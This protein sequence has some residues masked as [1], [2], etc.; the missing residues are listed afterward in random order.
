MQIITNHSQKELKHHGNYSFPFLV[1]HERLSRYESGSFLWH[2][3]PEVELTLIEQGEIIYHFSD[4]T[5]HAVAGDVLFGNS[6]ALHAG[7]MYRNHDC[8]YTPVTFDPRLIYGYDSSLI[9]QKYVEPI[10]QNTALTGLHLDRSA[11]W[12]EDA[13]RLIRESIAL[14][15]AQPPMYELDIIAGL[16]Q[17]WKLLFLNT[18]LP[19]SISA[20]D[21]RNSDRVRLILEYIEEHYA[22]PIRLEDIA[23]HIGLC[24]SECCR[25]FHRSMHMPLFEFLGE[26]RIEKSLH[27][28]AD[29][30]NSITVVAERA[31]FGDSNYYSK[32]FRKIKGCS[33]TK[34]RKQYLCTV[35]HEHSDTD[36]TTCPIAGDRCDS[37]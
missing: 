6:N 1:S 2:W 35:F 5:F 32:A 9:Q 37:D 18:N 34:Y 26:Y 8:T 31:G 14:Q 17:F 7:E 36:V 23:S 30:G 19:S 22:A 25:L 27:D 20:A 11:P 13:I 3:H 12:H 4:Q 33:P 29:P 24:K 21:R 10:I 28:L 15:E 16:Q